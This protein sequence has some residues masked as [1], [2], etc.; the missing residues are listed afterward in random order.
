ML[1]YNLVKTLASQDGHVSLDNSSLLM[2]GDPSVGAISF[3]ADA[4]DRDDLALT[5][6]CET[7]PA[8]MGAGVPVPLQCTPVDAPAV[9]FLDVTLRLADLEG[10]DA[11]AVLQRIIANGHAVCR[12]IAK[13]TRTRRPVIGQPGA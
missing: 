1:F 12:H 4:A 5:A 13:I 3:L 8:A 11:R 10:Q 7:I 2:E 9:V 6:Y